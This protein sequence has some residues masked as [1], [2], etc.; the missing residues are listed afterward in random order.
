MMI[1]GI[2]GWTPPQK[3]R[4]NG[5]ES[6]TEL[7]FPALCIMTGCRKRSVPYQFAL[8]CLW[9]VHN[10]LCMTPSRIDGLPITLFRVLYC[11]AAE[12]RC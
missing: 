3:I 8:Q 6:F 11:R 4:K 12:P 9:V 1:I 5:D 2:D 7:K 10:F